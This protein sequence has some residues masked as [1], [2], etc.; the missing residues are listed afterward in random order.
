M[1]PQLRDLG[2]EF[3]A[4]DLGGERPD[5]GLKYGK[6]DAGGDGLPSSRS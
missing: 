4:R 6:C 2:R 3:S 5:D 1:E